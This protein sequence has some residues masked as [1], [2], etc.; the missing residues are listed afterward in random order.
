[1]CKISRT[2]ELMLF[3]GQIFLTPKNCSH[4][5]SSFWCRPGFYILNSGTIPTIWTEYKDMK[6]R[7]F[8]QLALIQVPLTKYLY[9]SH[10]ICHHKTLRDARPRWVDSSHIYS[11]IYSWNYSWVCFTDG[12]TEAVTAQ[13]VLTQSDRVTTVRSKVYKC[14]FCF[15]DLTY[16]LIRWL[17]S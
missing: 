12:K 11:T 3:W 6:T 9:F 17:W 16:P 5:I 1:M 4:L 10:N 14:P 15:S 2:K 8:H 13:L 7:D